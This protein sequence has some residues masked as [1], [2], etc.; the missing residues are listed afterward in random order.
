MPERVPEHRE[1]ITLGAKP[2]DMPDTDPVGITALKSVRNPQ[3]IAPAGT[4]SKK[5]ALIPAAGPQLIPNESGNA[6]RVADR[7]PRGPL[8]AGAA[9]PPISWHLK[10]PNEKKSDDS[11]KQLR[12]ESAKSGPQYLFHRFPFCQFIDQFIEIADIPH[13]RILDL[14]YS[15]A[16]NDTFDQSASR[17]QLRRSLRKVSMSPVFSVVL[18]TPADCSPS[19]SK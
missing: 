11:E 15:D 13:H 16:A 5:K 7:Q 6:A 2:N 3:R 12:E 9:L 17:I 8:A 14:L 4:P 10:I 19:A 1:I 18:A